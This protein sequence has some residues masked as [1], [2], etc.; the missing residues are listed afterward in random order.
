MS[1]DGVWGSCLNRQFP[2]YSLLGKLDSRSRTGD[3]RFR[4]NLEPARVLS[5]VYKRQWTQSGGMYL[6]ELS[7]GCKGRGVSSSLAASLFHLIEPVDR[8]SQRLIHSRIANSWLTLWCRG[9]VTFRL[10]SKSER[11]Y[12]AWPRHRCRWTAQSNASFSERR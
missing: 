2:G 8:N 1:V 3:G 4:S 11:I 12:R 5:A 9:S 10:A 7:E 6:Q